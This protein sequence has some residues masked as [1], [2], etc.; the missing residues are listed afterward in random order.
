[1]QNILTQEQHI[2][3]DSPAAG[4]V[5]GERGMSPPGMQRS[6]GHWPPVGTLG[7]SVNLSSLTCKSTGINTHF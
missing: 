7:K 4:I 3:W 5:R 1:M 2:D 6:A